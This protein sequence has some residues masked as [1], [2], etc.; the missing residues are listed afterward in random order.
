MLRIFA[1]PP[2]H[3]EFENGRRASAWIGCFEAAMPVAEAAVSW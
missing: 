2:Y 1:A 3:V